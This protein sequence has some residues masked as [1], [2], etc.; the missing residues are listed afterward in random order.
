MAPLD[1]L[2]A[3]CKAPPDL[4]DAYQNWHKWERAFQTSLGCLLLVIG[5]KFPVAREA[6]RKE[7]VKGSRGSDEAK[8]V[9][10]A[11]VNTDLQFTDG[12]PSSAALRRQIDDIKG[13]LKVHGL[14][15]YMQKLGIVKR[16]TTLKLGASD[17][18]FD[19]LPYS[20]KARK[21][22]QGF[23]D[24]HETLQSLPPISTIAS[25][26]TAQSLMLDAL[27]KN[28]VCQL[29]STAKNSQYNRE[30]TFRA[31]ALARARA[32]G[33]RRL[34][35]SQADDILDLPGPDLKNVKPQLARL[36]GKKRRVADLYEKHGVCVA[37]E[38]I[39]MASCLRVGRFRKNAVSSAAA[40]KRTKAGPCEACF[41]R[42]YSVKKCREILGHTAPAR[43]KFTVGRKKGSKLIKSKQKKQ[44]PA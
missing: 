39:C 7:Y 16:G 27:S 35:Y 1:G 34:Y 26:K 11:L 5:L 29:K 37:P 43:A 28:G 24:M 21:A 4:Q 14:R 9:W 6:F 3:F 22:I 33:V 23:V 12:S 30:W 18:L 36:V 15:I 8:R 44:K 31:F 19:I 40:Q 2:T 17:Q 42:H 13:P 25:Y 38:Y 20:K 41:A 10:T 32:A